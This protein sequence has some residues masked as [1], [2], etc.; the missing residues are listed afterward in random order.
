ME[1]CLLTPEEW[2]CLDKLPKALVC[3]SLRYEHL[4]ERGLLKGHLRG[5]HGLLH[6][7]SL[8]PSSPSESFLKL[9]PDADSHVGHSSRVPD[10]LMD[11]LC[12]VVLVATG[13]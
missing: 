11:G 10:P 3:P 6:M 12:S 8:A 5:H 13:Q 1:P 4:L 9:L 2:T 7:D